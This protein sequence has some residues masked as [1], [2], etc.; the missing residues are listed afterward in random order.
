MFEDQIFFILD[1]PQNAQ[2]TAMFNFRSEQKKEFV[3]ICG[4]QKINLIHII[5]GQKTK[6]L[7]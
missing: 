5:C 1:F 2:T 3:H 7:N 6:P 4:K